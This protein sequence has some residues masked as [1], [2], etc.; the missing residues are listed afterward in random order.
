MKGHT[1]KEHK[2]S[3]A[4]VAGT[5]TQSRLQS[6]SSL[7]PGDSV[8][9]HTP[10]QDL[11]DNS[12][13]VKQLKAFQELTVAGP[14]MAGSPA[15]IQAKG[16]KGRQQEKVKFRGEDPYKNQDDVQA[17]LAEIAPDDG[18]IREY[19]DDNRAQNGG[20][21]AGWVALHRRNPEKLIALWNEVS[22]K[23]EE[24]EELKKEDPDA[25]VPDMDS[26]KQRV[27]AVQ[28]YL[29]AHD[30]F[31]SENE[32]GEFERPGRD[33]KEAADLEGED[34]EDAPTDTGPE[35]KRSITYGQFV[36]AIK[37]I[38]GKKGEVF[39]EI[40]TNAHEAQVQLVNGKVRSVCES[41]KAGI[42]STT[43]DNHVE[44]ILTSAFFEEDDEDAQVRVTMIAHQRLA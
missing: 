34:L 13:G 11:A 40:F 22:Q 10:W 7:Q 12:D 6:G 3:Q 27:E 18:P 43:H 20:L 30:H 28:I 25:P 31:V 36:P 4:A 17:Y 23:L 39:V 37:T 26:E 14:Q 16:K 8:G 32:E 38:A 29:K 9:R 2:T 1:T 21:C 15:V 41:E 35:H 33:A 5:T 44:S 19:I 42:I 24:W